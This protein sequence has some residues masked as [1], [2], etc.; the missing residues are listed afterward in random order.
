MRHEGTFES[1]IC[2]IEVESHDDYDQQKKY[3]SDYL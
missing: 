3:S 1:I 2:E